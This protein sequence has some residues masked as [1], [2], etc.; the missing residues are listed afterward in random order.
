MK[1][2]RNGTGHPGYKIQIA[3]KSHF[4]FDNESHLSLGWVGLP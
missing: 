1:D 3:L 2:L 4:V